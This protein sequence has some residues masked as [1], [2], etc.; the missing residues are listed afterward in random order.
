VEKCR[1]SLFLYVIIKH[2]QT[3]HAGS[4]MNMYS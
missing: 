3:Y 1:K 4:T 2:R